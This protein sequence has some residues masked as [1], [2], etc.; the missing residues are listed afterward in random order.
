MTGRVGGRVFETV[1]RTTVKLRDGQ[2]VV[3]WSHHDSLCYCKKLSQGT[4]G[5][6]LLNVVSAAR[7]HMHMS[8]L[9]LW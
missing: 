1:E 3:T 5:T 8:P 2:V 4:C 7:L 6:Q 9:L